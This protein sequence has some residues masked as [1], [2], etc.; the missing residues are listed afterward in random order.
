[1]S[2]TEPSPAEIGTW[3]GEL[4]DLAAYFERTGCTVDRSPTVE[5]LRALHRS[6]VLAIPFE[7]VDVVLGR[8]PG[9][10]IGHLQDKLVRRARGGYCYEQTLLFA[11]VLERLGYTVTGLAG[12]I[13]NGRDVHRPRSHAALRVRAGGQWWLADVGLGGERPLEP[14]PL[15]DGPVRRQGSWA[16]RL[17]ALGDGEWVLRSLRRDG[18]F[19]LYSVD[20]AR[21]LPGDY[22]VQNHYTATHPDSP[23][24]SKV[25]AQR[26]AADARYGL[27]GTQLW[28]TSGDG[29]T[30]QQEVANDKVIDTLRD[31]FGIELTQEERAAL[32][33]RLCAME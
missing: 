16:Y 33:P 30:E 18:W 14:I 27:R 26:T 22:A 19:D 12:R 10:D 28:I 32:A 23:F 15:T 4:L 3:G 20:L 21:Q 17:D 24:V 1:M 8:P 11:A 31:T 2:S 25:V 9:L 7:N 5:T 29:A 13:R 6:H